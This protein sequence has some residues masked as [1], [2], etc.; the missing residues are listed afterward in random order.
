MRVGQD[1]R[2]VTPSPGEKGLALGQKVPSGL[3]GRGKDPVCIIPL[4]N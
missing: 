1:T 3:G 4:S 2:P